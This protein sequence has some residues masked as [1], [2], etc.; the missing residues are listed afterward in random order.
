MKTVFILGA[1]VMQLPALNTAKEKGWYLCCADGNGSAIGRDLADEFFVIDLK[2]RVGIA[3]QA[4]SIREDRGLDGIFTAGTDFSATV[5]WVAGKLNLP[6]ISFQTAMNCTDKV[7]MRVAFL[8]DHVPSPGFL[9]IS[10]VDSLSSILEQLDFPL[11]VKPVDSMG[12]RGVCRVD[13]E[14]DLKDAVVS[15]ISYSR[16]DRA[17]VEEFIEGAEFSLDALI[18]EGKIR[19]TGFADRHIFFPPRFIE[20]GH[21]IPTS[22]KEEER[23]SVIEVFKQGIRSLGIT[24]GAAKGDIKLSD[25]G[26][27]VGEIAARLSGGYMSGWTYPYSSGISSTAGGLNL[28]V[29]LPM[30][31]PENEEDLTCA[32]RAFIS[33]PGKVRTISG[34]E[35]AHEKKYVRDL[36]IRIHEGSEVIFP[37]NNVEKCGNIIAVH[38]DRHTAVDSAE[39]GAAEVL[40]FLEADH[41]GTQEFL[42]RDYNSF[43]GKAFSFQSDIN[44]IWLDG[45]LADFTPDYSY[46]KE[47]NSDWNIDYIPDVKDVGKDWQ[48]RS[49]DTL[50]LLIQ[51]HTDFSL[52]EQG[53]NG[54]IQSETALF[55][56]TFLTGGLQGIL[57]LADKSGN[58]C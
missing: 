16:T 36:F 12:A 27:V 50:F 40:I 5:A 53:N 23:Q 55:W 43:P 29:G 9:E 8:R 46:V 39:K 13:A 48:G 17:I 32:E 2:D 38:K 35:S 51:K 30:D 34:L 1:G 4:E 19:I 14:L 33:I 58:S 57:W 47:K 49:L 6:G 7:R 42:C 24:H 20:M 56:Y 54:L 18:E 26:P 10:D 31:I 44:I 45:L 11:V 37:L 52:K 22:L 3:R 41:S 25:K 28:S 21:T 15:A